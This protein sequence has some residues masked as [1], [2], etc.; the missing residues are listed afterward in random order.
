MLLIAYFLAISEFSFEPIYIIPIAILLFFG[1]VT[2]VSFPIFLID[3]V[4]YKEG[5]ITISENEKCIII[6]RKG[7]EKKICFK[8]IDK[9]KLSDIESSINEKENQFRVIQIIRNKGKSKIELVGKPEVENCPMRL[10]VDFSV[11]Y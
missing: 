11:F 1:I 3:F 10:E 2:L 4:N 9:I 6:E 7:L 5:T 8:D